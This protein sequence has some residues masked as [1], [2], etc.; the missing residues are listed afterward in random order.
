ML[1]FTVLVDILWICLYISQLWSPPL[2]YELTSNMNA[3]LRLTFTLS[4]LC[5]IGKLILL[6]LLASQFR[7]DE[8]QIYQIKVL[9]K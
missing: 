2:N 9:N 3:Y 5:M 4:I 1:L 6:Y 8:G 7:L